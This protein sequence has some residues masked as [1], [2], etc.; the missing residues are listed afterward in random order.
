MR[1]IWTIA[2]KD[3]YTTF[4]DRNLVLTMI[5]TPLIIAT[6][7]GLAF[8]KF[9]SGD[10]VIQHIPIAIVNL[11]R[12]SNPQ[13]FG[14][15]VV[16]VFTA[17][18]NNEPILGVTCNKTGRGAT[19]NNPTTLHDLTDAVIMDDPDVARAGVDNGRFTAAIIIPPDFSQKLTVGSGNA[20][21]P[22]SIE[23][24]ANTGRAVPSA[25]VRGIVEY[26]VNLIMTGNIAAR[27]TLET[28]QETYG[29]LQMAAV[30]ADSRFEQTISCAFTSTLNPLRIEQQTVAGQ[31][32]NSIAALLVAFGS[33][34][35][36]FFALFTGQQGVLSVFEERRQGTL[37]RLVISPTPR[38]YILFGKLL[39]TFFQC[40]FQLA[41]LG[42]ALTF[43]GS[44]LSGK[45]VLIWGANLPGLLLVMMLAAAAVTGMGTLMAGIAR[46]PEQSTISSQVLNLSLGLLGGGFGLQL[47]EALSRFSMIYWG[48]DAFR[49]LSSGR[50]DITLN[51]L[52]LLAHGIVL[53]AIGWWLFNRRLDI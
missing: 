14:Q 45:L 10:V 35:A 52:V 47:P 16:S 51:L 30:A 17:S 20:V 18:S 27:A 5:A 23:V 41:A 36:M 50:G 46:T 37:Q 22:V 39:G 28:V 44:L 19:N 25:I 3:I 4:S 38:L 26:L 48:S 12:G 6:L 42:V 43:V 53:F 8:G 33:A 49:K 31:Q 34:Q 2:W 7:V 21:E 40:L 24:Y 13:N 9:S 1:R 11:D 32:T 15:I 29:S